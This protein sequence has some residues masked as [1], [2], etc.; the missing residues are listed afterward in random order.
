MFRAQPISIHAFINE[1]VRTI[2]SNILVSGD[3]ILLSSLTDTSLFLCTSERPEHEGFTLDSSLYAQHCLFDRERTKI[4][5]RRASVVLLETAV[6]WPIPGNELWVPPAARFG[7]R[8]RQAAGLCRGD[9][10]AGAV[11]GGGGGTAR[12]YSE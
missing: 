3:L 5:P 9:D 4:Y 12:R 1:G 11:G 10:K 8:G 6:R 2:K 7:R